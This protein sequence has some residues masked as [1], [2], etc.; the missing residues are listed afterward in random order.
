MN[1]RDLK[2]HGTGVASLALFGDLTSHLYRPERYEVISDLVSVKIMPGD[3]E[4]PNIPDY[5]PVINEDA[6]VQSR[7]NGAVILCSAITNKKPAEN[8][9]PSSTSSAID[10]VV[11]NGGNCD[12]LYLISSG[13]TEENSGLDYPD[14]LYDAVV[15]DPSQSW[16]A[17][18]VGAYTEKV[19]LQDELY[20]DLEIV[21]PSG[22]IAPHTSTSVQFGPNQL[23]KPE[24]LMEGGNSVLSNMQLDDPN[25]LQLVAANAKM[26]GDVNYFCDF[27]AT[28]AAVGL[29]ANLAAKILHYNPQ[30][31][32]LSVR[33][34]MVHSAHWTD[35]MIEMCTRQDGTVDKDLLVHSCGYGVPCE[36]EAIV[37]SGNYATFINEGILK[38]FKI[39]T[40]N[41]LKFSSM[42]LY[43]LPWPED[44]LRNM[45]E[46][47]VELKITLSYYIN[48][49]PVA[50]SSISKYAYQSIRLKFDVNMPT[51][52]EGSF[53]RRI[54]HMGDED[55]QDNDA[56]R[57]NVGIN[58]RNQG[59]VISDSI[60]MS[61]IDA[62]R[63]N[64][65]AVYPASGWYKY[66]KDKVDAA[67]KYSLVVSLKT[68]EQNIYTEIAQRIG[69]VI[70]IEIDG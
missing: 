34:L 7:N 66:K 18:S 40:G 39:G 65:I 62:T 21:A 68:P 44:I 56:S 1:V 48:P 69:V 64:M 29:A 52:T 70:P 13:N 15:H 32:P 11:Y 30:I 60:T 20:R 36:T 51:E 2:N 46:E 67:I 9:I 61:A 25:G 27:N 3:R 17:L 6:V 16:N 55:V 4:A 50:K 28:S 53:K 47:T 45:A 8:G 22:G 41:D 63:C 24:I 26:A 35:K 12:C 59:C 5:Y 38:P 33:A 37:S 49:S 58:R 19:A 23:I 57:W 54:S 31:S 14:Y 43:R 10:Q 42:H